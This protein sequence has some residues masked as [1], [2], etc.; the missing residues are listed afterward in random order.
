MGYLNSYYG[1]SLSNVYPT[2][3]VQ[4]KIPI[5]FV[6]FNSC[7]VFFFFVADVHTLILYICK[8]I[9]GSK[10]SWSLCLLYISCR[11]K[12]NLILSCRVSLLNTECHDRYG[13]T[14]RLT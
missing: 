7:H 9:V 2:L 10:A 14:S 1:A 8:Q 5:I 4:F 12:I 3:L 11:L 13:H 6:G